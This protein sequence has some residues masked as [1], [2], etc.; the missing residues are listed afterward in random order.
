LTLPQL[1]VESQGA[2]IYRIIAIIENAGFLPTYTSKKALERKDVRAIEAELVVPEGIEIIAG[3]RRQELGQLEGRSNK[4]WNWSSGSSP[5]DNRCKLEWVVKG[6]VGA[7]LELV[8]RA[9]RAGTLH[10]EI[11]LLTD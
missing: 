8:V 9:Q 7:Q 6:S 1:L 2:Q 3:K 11:T 4:I 5:T 10:Q